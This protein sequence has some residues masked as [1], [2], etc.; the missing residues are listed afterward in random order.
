M[1]TRMLALVVRSTGVVLHAANTGLRA[2][3]IVF[4]A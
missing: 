3:H 4:A 1:K 2:T